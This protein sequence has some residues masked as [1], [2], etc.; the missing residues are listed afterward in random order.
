VLFE[1]AEGTQSIGCQAA[2]AGGIV[3]DGCASRA[4]WDICKAERLEREK[5][6]LEGARQLERW[7]V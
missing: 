4:G 1:A 3:I 7:S 6:G 5:R 2:A